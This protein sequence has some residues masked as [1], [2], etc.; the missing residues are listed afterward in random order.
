M[1]DESMILLLLLRLL[2]RLLLDGRLRCRSVLQLLHLA[3]YLIRNFPRRLE[4]AWRNRG[5]GPMIWVGCGWAVDFHGG[6]RWMSVS[7]SVRGEGEEEACDVGG[8]RLL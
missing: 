3:P 2:L 7:V 6:R 8:I 4:G 1:A 5:P